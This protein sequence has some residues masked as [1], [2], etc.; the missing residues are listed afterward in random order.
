MSQER[1]CFQFSSDLGFSSQPSRARF[2]TR[3][4]QCSSQTKIQKSFWTTDYLHN[5]YWL[6]ILHMKTANPKLFH[7]Y[8][9]DYGVHEVFTAVLSP[10]YEFQ[11]LKL[12]S[13]YPRAKQGLQDTALG[14]SNQNSVLMTRRVTANVDGQ[15]DRIQNSTSGHVQDGVSRL[16]SLEEGRPT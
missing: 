14:K 12:P 5:F 15:V 3:L 7:V 6:N 9:F 10:V 16:G 8:S 2:I 13:K 4:P 1:M 11:S